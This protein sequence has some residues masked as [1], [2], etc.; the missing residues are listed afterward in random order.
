MT[1]ADAQLLAAMALEAAEARARLED[2]AAAVGEW[3]A[4]LPDEL[5]AAALAGAQTFDGTGQRL[6]ALSTLLEGLARGE[7][8]AA[9]VAAVPLADMAARLAGTPTPLPDPSGDLLLFE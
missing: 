8:A 4:A 6:A 1:P 9:L 7:D 3:V 2:A 5:R